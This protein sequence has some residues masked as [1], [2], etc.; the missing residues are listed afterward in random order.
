MSAAQFE[1]A[2]LILATLR[3][4]NQTLATAESLTGGLLSGAITDVP[5]SSDVFLGGIIAYSSAMKSALLKVDGE[6]IDTHGV[7]SAEV[8]IAMARGAS[9][10]LGSD[11]AIAT[12]GVAGPGPSDGIAAGTV[13]VAIVGPDRALFAEEF[14]IS[15]NRQE[16]RVRTIARAFASF[17]R[18]LGG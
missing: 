17:T 3:S 18:I 13:W 6:L 11:W 2:S 5:G 8:A 1:A 15:G 4:A 7:V 10:V 12:T 16:V 9:N 14:I